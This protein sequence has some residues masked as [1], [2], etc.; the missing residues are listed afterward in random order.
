DGTPLSYSAT[1]LP[2]GAALD[3]STGLL[4]WTPTALDQGEHAIRITVSD[5]ETSTSRTLLLVASA[6]PI[7]PDVLIELTPGFPVA[8]GQPVLVQAIAS[9]I[10]DI[11]SLT[12]TIGGVPRTLDE[13]GRVSFTPA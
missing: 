7:P 6:T 8:V 12:L 5:G 11:A 4:T 3:A 2:D 10:A 9:G 1:G 13:L